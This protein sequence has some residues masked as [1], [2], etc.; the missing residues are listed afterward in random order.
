MCDEY[1]CN[2]G[3]NQGR[4]CPVRMERTRQAK[5]LLDREARFDR[6]RRRMKNDSQRE[7]GMYRQM[8]RAVWIL[9]FSVIGLA[10]MAAKGGA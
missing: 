3:C 2:H 7:A 5:E 10:V 8:E 9:I 6:L 4:N 1:C